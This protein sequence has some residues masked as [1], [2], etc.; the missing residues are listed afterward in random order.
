M[1]QDALP[2]CLDGAIEG[3]VWDEPQLGILCDLKHRSGWYLDRAGGEHT[4]AEHS[5]AAL[6][7]KLHQR[8]RHIPSVGNDPIV[9]ALH[10]HILASIG[11]E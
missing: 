5:M 2:P 8:L 6:L 7:H 10:A 3:E 11:V 1:A 9:F 4:P